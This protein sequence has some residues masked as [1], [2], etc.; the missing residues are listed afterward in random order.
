MQTVRVSPI[1]P[2]A[3]QSRPGSP[4]IFGPCA[5]IA[6]VA[7]AVC[8]LAAGCSLSPLAKHASAF[9][10]VAGSVIDNSEDAYRAAIRLRQ[11]E[12]VAAAVYDYDKNP[13]WSPYKDLK[14]LLTPEQLDARIDVLDGLKAYAATL[15][16]LTSSKPSADLETAAGVGTNLRA[17]NQTAATAFKTAIPNA[18]VMSA[19]NANAISTG[20]L[21]LADYLIARKVKGSLPKVTQDMN[22]I[23]QNLCEYL[24][25]DITD[26]RSQADVDYQNLIE[27]QDLFIRHQGAALTPIQ[28]RDEVGKLLQFAAQQKANDKM[29]AGLQKAL[30]TLAM[31]HQALAAAAQGNNPGSIQQS[32]ADLA[33]AGQSLK[34]FYKSLPAQ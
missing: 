7:L 25:R 6:S 10:A 3:A 32:I 24:N 34:T 11:D 5:L 27:A 20:V 8:F 30:H 9:S 4:G 19:A 17:L 31:T 18:P 28:H 2:E 33:A 15:V 29:L 14:P 22:P 12:Q 1:E 26:L 13:S 23:V 21:A 16:E